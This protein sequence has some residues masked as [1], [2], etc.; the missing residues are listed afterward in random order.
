MS[1]SFSVWISTCQVYASIRRGFAGPACRFMRTYVLVFDFGVARGDVHAF[2]FQPEMDMEMF[3]F[4]D[5][6]RF[7]DPLLRHERKRCLSGNWV[8]RW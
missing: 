6:M 8:D 1:E 3:C 7:S 4:F 5:M 2:G